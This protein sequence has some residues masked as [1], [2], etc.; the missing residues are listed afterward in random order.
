MMDADKRMP[1]SRP[2]PS[3]WFFPPLWWGGWGPTGAPQVLGGCRFPWEPVSRRCSP[4]AAGGKGLQHCLTQAAR[5][6][7]SGSSLGTL[8]TAFCLAHWMLSS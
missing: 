8:A 6:S 5:L 1:S 3:S 4:A 2:G 7:A